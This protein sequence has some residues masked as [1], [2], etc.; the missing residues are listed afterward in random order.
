M[1][2]IQNPSAAFQAKARRLAEQ[3]LAQWRET[4]ARRLVLKLHPTPEGV[5]LAL[6]CG[7]AVVRPGEMID[8]FLLVLDFA[9]HSRDADLQLCR[10][11]LEQESRWFELPDD[12]REELLP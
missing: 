9:L 3:H 7:A 8:P 4:V 2:T 11:F 5:V 6:P 12:V 10:Q 1:G